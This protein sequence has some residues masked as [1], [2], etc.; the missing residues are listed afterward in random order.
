MRFGYAKRRRKKRS[1]GG[2]SAI[3]RRNALTFSLLDNF[4]DNLSTGGE[5]GIKIP[6]SQGTM[7]ENQLD[8]SAILSIAAAAAVICLATWQ[9]PERGNHCCTEAKMIHSKDVLRQLSSYFLLFENPGRRMATLSFS[10]FRENLFR[11]WRRR[12]VSVYATTEQRVRSAAWKKKGLWRLKV[13][14]SSLLNLKLAKLDPA[15]DCDSRW[16]SI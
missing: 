1:N 10:S 4:P 8:F 11:L 9:P 5:V 2:V 16:Q 13:Q 6:Y 12:R 7:C 14:F 15:S 3:E